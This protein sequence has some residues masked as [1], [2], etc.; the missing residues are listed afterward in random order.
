MFGYHRS[1]PH[2]EIGIEV[3]LDQQRQIDKGVS[4]HDSV[5]GLQHLRVYTVMV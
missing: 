2:H 3:I 1:E 5:E 4:G